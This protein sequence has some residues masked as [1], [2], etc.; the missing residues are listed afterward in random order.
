MFPQCDQS[1][2]ERYKIIHWSGPYVSNGQI[3]LLFKQ[4]TTYFLQMN[5]LQYVLQYRLY[6]EMKQCVLQLLQTLEEG[7]KHSQVSS[8]GSQ[9]KLPQSFPHL[10]VQ[11]S[12]NPLSG[13][14]TSNDVFYRRCLSPSTMGVHSQNVLYGRKCTPQIC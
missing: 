8:L 4:I 5:G 9:S 7:Q 13:T 12:L 3:F 11:F 14:D 6:E 2:H 10:R 1:H